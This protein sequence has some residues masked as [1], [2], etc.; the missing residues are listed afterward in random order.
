MRVRFGIRTKLVGI[1][2]LILCV[3]AVAIVSM[4]TRFFSE[5]NAARV[6]ETNL[7]SARLIAQEVQN[8]LGNLTEKMRLLGTTMLQALPPAQL[9]A[10]QRPF[11]EREKD[12]IAASVVSIAG[13]QARVLGQAA[14]ETLLKQLDVTR[15]ESSRAQTSVI[16]GTRLA[17]GQELIAAAQLKGSVPVIAV[18]VPLLSD[19]AGH[20]T[21]S[22][23]AVLKQD[24]LL[25]AVA[26]AG[27]ITSYLVDSQGYLLAHPDQARA[28]KKE[29]LGHLGIVK[30]LLSGAANN[31]QTRFVDPE[32]G[33]P[34]FGAFKTV[35]FAG[36]GVISQVE[37]AK[38]LEAARRVRRFSAI[39]TGMVAI[40]AF[41]IVFFFSLSLTR[42]LVSLVAASDAI[43]AGQYDLQLKRGA[44]DEIGDLT[45]AFNHM[46]QGL[47][48]REKIKSAFSKFH[49]KDI[50]DK[51]LSGE[52]NLV[53]ERKKVTIF[54]SDIRSFTTISESMQ[55]EEVVELVNGYMT[56]MV[57]II[58][59]HGGVVDK[60][61]GDAIMAVYGTPQSFGDDALRAVSAALRMRA[62]LVR[63]NESRAAQ[64]KSTISI[65]MGMNT[66]D[67]VAGNI[68]SPERMEYTVLGDNVNLA[69]RMESQTKEYQTDIL[70]STSTYLEIKDW[71]E[72]VPRGTTK[73][74]GKNEEVEIYEVKG[75]YSGREY[76]PA[77]S[78]ITG[79]TLSTP[80]P[81]RAEM[82]RGSG[83]IRPAKSKT[84]TAAVPPP[85]NAEMTR[86]TGVSRP[87]ELAVPVL[88]APTSGDS[89]GDGTGEAA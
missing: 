81:P 20:V 74:K 37:E 4:A 2:N 6:Q 29:N 60:Y 40:V 86:G 80:P 21:H 75:F 10:L 69:S 43:A 30:Q 57:R 47:A 88:E 27:I 41:V 17:T 87:L 8:D 64:G 39:I 11:F 33:V 67:V 48:E 34:W 18:A 82:T 50:A 45:S 71:I 3:A 78:G 15:E 26:D 70:V 31:G 51:I 25:K 72:C 16:D 46:A 73:V 85:P 65:G 63:F 58:F 13:G 76:I 19:D 77:E 42:P 5:D 9:E 23:V 62:E 38:A 61:V 84:G 1:I 32:T 44:N 55:P 79:E 14:N 24:R 52:L 68:G 66:G 35:G 89:S 22:A 59:A 49:S 53:G 54:F 36:I 7:D 28:L 83:I 56:R 12:L